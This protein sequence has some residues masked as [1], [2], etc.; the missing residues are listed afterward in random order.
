MHCERLLLHQGNYRSITSHI[1]LFLC[2]NV[3]VLLLASF[4]YII[5]LPVLVTMLP[6]R[7]SDLV[8]PTTETVP[9]SPHFPPPH[10]L[11]TT[12][13][14]CFESVWGV[15]LLLFTFFDST[16]QLEKIATTYKLRV[17][18]YLVWIFRTSRLGDSISSNP[19]RTAP[20]RQGRSQVI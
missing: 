14:L 4:S 6:V 20:R 3:Q 10:S 8:Y 11:A 9:A 16:G 15:L 7:A 2:E 17:T 1:Y 5:V 18:F 19:E 13:L 12:F